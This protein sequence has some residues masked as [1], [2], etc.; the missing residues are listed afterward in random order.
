MGEFFKGW[1]RKAG[2]VAL[3]LALLTMGAWIKSA[4]YTDLIRVRYGGTSVLGISVSEGRM[5]CFLFGENIPKTFDVHWSSWQIPGPLLDWGRTGKRRSFSIRLQYVAIP[6]TILS[7]YLI[8]WKPR[9]R[10]AKPES[11][12]PIS[13]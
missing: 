12:P 4:N 3:G 2:I 7:A 1:R 9:K 5:S 6:L 11:A 10:L 8:L 13:N